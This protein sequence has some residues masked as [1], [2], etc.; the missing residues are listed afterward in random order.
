MRAWADAVPASTA[1]RVNQDGYLPDA[2]KLAMVV[3]PGAA[4]FTVRDAATGKQVWQGRLSSAKSDAN[5]GDCVQVADFSGLRAL[6]RYRLEVPGDGSSSN[7][8]I[9]PDAYDQVSFHAERAAVILNSS[10]RRIL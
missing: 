4:T 6:G 1:I 3:Q 10:R 8:A 2:A 5:S 7:F 9:A